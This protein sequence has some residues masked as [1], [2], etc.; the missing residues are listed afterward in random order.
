METICPGC[1]NE[2]YK[3]LREQFDR[4]GFS[5]EFYHVCRYCDTYLLATTRPYPTFKLT[6]QLPDDVSERESDLCSITN[7]EGLK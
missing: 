1:N 4:F 6:K 7:K 2:I 3:D 5:N